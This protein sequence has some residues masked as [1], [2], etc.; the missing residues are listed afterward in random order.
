MVEEK[1]LKT[2]GLVVPLPS[3]EHR[4][5]ISEYIRASNSSSVSNVKYYLIIHNYLIIWNYYNFHLLSSCLKQTPQCGEE[6]QR[7]LNIKGASSVTQEHVV[8]GTF[9][10]SD[11]FRTQSSDIGLYITDL[12]RLPGPSMDIASYHPES[13]KGKH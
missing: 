9:P 11:Y 2:Q 4:Q 6:Q 8:P 7:P 10:R 13:D 1:A 5:G 3:S 12:E